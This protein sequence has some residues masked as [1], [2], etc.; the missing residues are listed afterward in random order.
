MAS[1]D[2]CE[3]P[4]WCAN[5]CGFFGR[6]DTLNLCSKCYR[7]VCLQ[8]AR[9]QASDALKFNAIFER[10]A[11]LSVTAESVVAD[12]APSA[13]D[14]SKTGTGSKNN[15][16]GKSVERCSCCNKRVGLA[17]GFKCRCGNM[18]CTV[19]R[20]P[21]EHDCTFD[22]KAAGRDLL[23]RANPVVRTDKLERI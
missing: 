2:E 11:R 23:A 6:E 4:R 10:L 13:D 21:E 8:D 12:A 20:Y 9:Q 14:S 19:H 5:G 16:S 15:Q 17:K 22:F 18:Y 3:S 1:E 7:E